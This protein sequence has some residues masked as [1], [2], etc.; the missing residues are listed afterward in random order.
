MDPNF[1]PLP[2]PPGAFNCNLIHPFVTVTDK[3]EFTACW[4]SITVLDAR[5]IHLYLTLLPPTA[6]PPFAKKSEFTSQEPND[7][8]IC[9][10]YSNSM[11]GLL[12]LKHSI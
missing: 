7:V 6:T 3:L 10:K 9:S 11:K 2:P 4:R 12:N 5:A 1:L 8:I